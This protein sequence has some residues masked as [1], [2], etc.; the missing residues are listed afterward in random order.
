[1][2]LARIYGGALRVT[3]FL[4]GLAVILVL[5]N[6]Y[7]FMG[8][9][10]LQTQLNQAQGFIN[11]S[12][13]LAQIHEGLVRGL[14]VAAEGRNDE[15]IRELLAQHGIKATLN[16]PPAQSGQSGNPAPAAQA[17]TAAAA[18]ANTQKKN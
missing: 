15:A 14:A 10:T 18:P 3:P 13:R 2:L 4:A 8:N 12:T 11:Q 16:T 17:P 1:M 6:G 7:L 5:V 9:Q